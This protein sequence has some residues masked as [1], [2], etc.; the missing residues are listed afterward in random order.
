MCINKT[1]SKRKTQR[2]KLVFENFSRVFFSSREI[3]KKK[4]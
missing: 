3:Y 2:G 1:K 4:T